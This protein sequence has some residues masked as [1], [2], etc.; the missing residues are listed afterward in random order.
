[1]RKVNQLITLL[2][3]SFFIV[4]QVYANYAKKGDKNPGY[5]I[6]NNGKKIEGKIISGSITDNEVKVHFIHPG[7]NKKTTYSPKD[8]KAYGYQVIEVDDLGLEYEDWKH[9][10]RHKVDYPPKPF[11]KT[12]VF[13]EKE[14][15]GAI[16]LY[17]YYIESRA[18]VK[19]PYRYVYYVKDDTGKLIKV[20]REAFSKIAKSIFG[21]YSALTERLGEKDF[22][23][24][25][26]DRMVRDFNYWVINQHDKDEYRVAMKQD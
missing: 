20:E 10:E 14:E 8:I 19:K 9:Y 6:L 23:Y 21:N 12:T 16:T 11:G 4:G 2:F 25:N 13:I 1:M 26:L 3:I 24:R 17:C 5:I 22:D 7:S 18:N 15:D